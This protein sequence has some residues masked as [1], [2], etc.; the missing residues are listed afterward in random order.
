[1]LDYKLLEALGCVIHELGFDKASQKLFITQSA[2][3]QRIKALED[4]VGQILVTRTT[5]P[6]V[7]LD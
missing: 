4:Q 2:V 5:P 6:P 1:M 3:S 7:R